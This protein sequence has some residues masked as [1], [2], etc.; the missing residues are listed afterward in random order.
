MSNESGKTF[1]SKNPWYDLYR[2][3]KRRCEDINHKT[4]KYCGALGIKFMLTMHEVEFLFSRDGGHFMKTPSLDRLDATKHYCFDNCRVIEK[5][6]NER[7]P[8]DKV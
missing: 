4:Y 7:R 3:A 8:H 1:R 5:A 6:E 2:G